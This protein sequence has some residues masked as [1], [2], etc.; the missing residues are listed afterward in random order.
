MICEHEWSPDGHCRLCRQWR[1]GTH[2]YPELVAEF[3]RALVITGMQ[4]GV[5]PDTAYVRECVRLARDFY[6]E[7]EAPSP[8]PTPEPQRRSED[9]AEDWT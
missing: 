8:R 5:A 2:P 9:D 6:A 1:G 3:G 7:V 4:C